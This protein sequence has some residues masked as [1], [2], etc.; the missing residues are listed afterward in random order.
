MSLFLIFQFHILISASLQLMLIFPTIILVIGASRRMRFL[1][2]PWLIVFGIFQLFL[3]LAI[4]LC[5]TNLP[6]EFKMLSAAIAVIEA[7]V[8]FPWWFGVIHLFSEFTRE[9]ELEDAKTEA[10]SST[11]GDFYRRH[12]PPS[13]QQP[14]HH[15]HHRHH[16]VRP[17]EYMSAEGGTEEVNSFSIGRS[18]LGTKISEV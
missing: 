11:R 6:A 8:I 18:S 14:H 16:V 17:V 2:L 15:H 13:Q 1:L 12:P 4:L 10:A 7:F 5:V 9:E 3:L